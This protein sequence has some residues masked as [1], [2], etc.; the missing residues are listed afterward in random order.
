[1]SKLIY[2]RSFF[3]CIAVLLLGYITGLQLG[4]ITPYAFRLTSEYGF[5]LPIIG[6]L[7]SL[8]TLFVAIFALPASRLIPT[9]G[10]ARM[11]KVGAATVATGAF[12]FIFADTL[13]MMIVVRIVEATG[14][15]IT[16]ISAPSYIVAKAPENLKAVFLALWSS[17]VPIGFALSNT[18]GG[19]LQKQTDL[20]IIWSYYAIAAVVVAIFVFLS[21]PNTP[22]EKPDSPNNLNKTSI[23]WILVYSFGTY[24]FLSI[25]FFAFMPSFIKMTGPQLLAPGVIPLFVPLG[26]FCAAFLFARASLALASRTISVG[27]LIIAIASFFCF[28][29]AASDASIYRALFAFGCGITAASIFTSVPDLTRSSMEATQTIGAIAQAGGLMVLIGAPFAGFIIEMAGWQTLGISFGF[30]AFSASIVAGA[31]ALT[32]KLE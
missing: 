3:S 25:G 27:F 19:T 32:R 24:G 18:L 16:V 31:A 22:L 7:T 28:P 10:L 15:I 17:F 5:S 9:F 20:Q 11:V 14:H 4:R 8:V 30:A 26:S 1:M 2:Q 21:L 29:L 6:W 23:A 13:T 12:L